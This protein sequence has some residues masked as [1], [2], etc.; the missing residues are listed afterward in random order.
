MSD[1]DYYRWAAAAERS[2]EMRLEEARNKRETRYFTFVGLLVFASFMGLILLGIHG[3]AAN[4]ARQHELEMACIA[5]G[6]SWKGGYGQDPP[7]CTQEK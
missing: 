3:C 5:K 4:A 7:E 1:D 2:E 6:G